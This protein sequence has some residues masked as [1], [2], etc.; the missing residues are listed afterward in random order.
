MST[1]AEQP[2][3]T[4]LWLRAVEDR[5]K[6]RRA[7]YSGVK[8][9][10]RRR[11]GRIAIVTD[12]AC[13]LPTDLQTGELALGGMG[14]GIS[15]VPIPVMLGEQ[16]YP[17]AGPELA[18]QLP[19]ALAQ[20]AKV[21]TSRPSPGRL[22]QTYR[23]LQQ[24]GYSGVV[25]VHLSSKLSGT[26]EAA[27]LAADQVS[28]PVKVVDTLQ[29]GF[30]LGQAV[31]EAAVTARL[32]GSLHQVA[33]AA[34]KQAAAASSF[35][36]VP[37]LE[38]LRRGGR[39]SPVAGMIGSLLNV[40]PVLALRNGEVSLLERTHS[41]SRAVERLIEA[42]RRNIAQR[43]GAEVAGAGR[44]VRLAV[45]CFGDRETATQIAAQIQEYSVEPVPILELPA[46]LAAH[47]GLGAVAIVATEVI[48]NRS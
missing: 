36:A 6:A 37:N 17:E 46:G 20:G 19:L 47:L 23:Q 14:T 15:C 18:A 48:P 28:I 39:L 31:L 32:A 21:Q 44:D 7:E 1:P 25:S 16:M 3:A 2:D 27:Q 29:A 4:A 26:V 12:S 45:H 8:P 10:T 40:R 9:N 38:Q 35:F 24:Q 30:G 22:A 42:S 43:A 41:F 11:R 13:G 33:E 5:L 34:A